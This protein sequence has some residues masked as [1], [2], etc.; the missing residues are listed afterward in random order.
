MPL[1]LHRPWGLHP[2]LYF[3]FLV[4]AMAGSKSYGMRRFAFT[5]F[6]GT[7]VLGFAPKALSQDDIDR[8]RPANN[9]PQTASPSK[10]PTDLTEWKFL[11]DNLAVEAR[12][13]EPEK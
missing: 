3:L 12:T 5:V 7:L 13:L 6:I 9:T 2:R 8:K 10:N 4:S 1:S 11:L